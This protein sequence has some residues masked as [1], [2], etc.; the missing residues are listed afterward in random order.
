MCSGVRLSVEG[1]EGGQSVEGRDREQSEEGREGGQSEEGRE[2]DNQK[3]GGR[4][5]VSRGQGG[6]FLY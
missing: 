4:C 5:T 2:E 1:K 3:R 6:S